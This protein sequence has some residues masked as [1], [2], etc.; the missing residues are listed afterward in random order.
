MEYQQQNLHENIF[1]KGV[2]NKKIL[3]IIKE[4][5]AIKSRSSYNETLIKKEKSKVEKILRNLGYFKS[6]IDILITQNDN[7]LVNITYEINLG[8]KSKTTLT[9][10]KT[11][12]TELPADEQISSTEETLEE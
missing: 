6:N 9:Q 2:K 10:P 12:S 1:Y 3:E 5:S 8:D 11:S 7:N 4:N